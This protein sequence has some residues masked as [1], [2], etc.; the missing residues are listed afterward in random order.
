MIA[1]VPARVEAEEARDDENE[2]DRREGN[3]TILWS[4]AVHSMQSIY[5]GQVVLDPFS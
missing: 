4:G 3:C 5:S 2:H 1:E